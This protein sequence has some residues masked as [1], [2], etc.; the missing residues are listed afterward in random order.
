MNRGS[1]GS[2]LEKHFEKSEAR[3]PKQIRMTEIQMTETEK[4]SLNLS[5]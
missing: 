5:C 3:N 4:R 2:G 1:K